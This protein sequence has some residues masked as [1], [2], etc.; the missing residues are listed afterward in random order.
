MYCII[1]FTV[2]YITLQIYDLRSACKGKALIVA[3][4]RFEAPWLTDLPGYERDVE[5]LADMWDQMGCHVLYPTIT[6]PGRHLTAS[7]CTL[8]SCFL[9]Y[10]TINC[11]K[12]CSTKDSNS[13]DMYFYNRHKK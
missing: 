11:M 9:Y 8:L 1:E 7:V 2:T 4:P 6:T 10:R 12:V 3:I 5:C 13:K